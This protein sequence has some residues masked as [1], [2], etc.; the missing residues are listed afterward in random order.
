MPSFYPPVKRGLIPAHAGKTVAQVVWLEV[1]WAHPRSRGENV[2]SVRSSATAA[3]SSPLT[4]GKP[5][6]TRAAPTGGGLIPAH[7]GKTS[8]RRRPRPADRAHPRSRGENPDAPGI[9]A[10][11][12]GSSPLTRGKPERHG[13]VTGR[14][15]LI[16]AHAG[17][18]ATACTN[19]TTCGAHPRSRGENRSIRES[20]RALTG[21]SPL[22]RGKLL[23]FHLSHSERRLIPAHAGKTDQNLRRSAR[24]RAHP[25]SRGENTG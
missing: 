21:S 12:W 10:A 1:F 14:P 15:G 23:T 17:K 9:A 4:R 2:S 3:G 22:T 20:S 8:A 11:I 25:R 24:S 7:A 6:H 5:A 13:A 18:T 16:P 19:A